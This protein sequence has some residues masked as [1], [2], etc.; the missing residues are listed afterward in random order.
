MASVKGTEKDGKRKVVKKRTRR[1]AAP[2]KETLSETPAVTAQIHPSKQDLQ[3]GPE[4]VGPR[5]T[6]E[7]EKDEK[8]EGKKKA[9][10]YF[11]AV[12]RRKTAVARVRLST[13]QGDF[14]VNS[15]PCSVYFPTL[16]LRG[17]AEDALAKMKLSGHFRVSA[18]ISGGGIHAQAEALRHGLSRCLVKFNADFRK[19]LKRVKFLTRDSRMRERKKFGLKKARRAPQWQKR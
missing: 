14:T 17:I 10:R 5:E 4:V 9:E 3:T 7:F 18:K 13:R 12:G 1:T 11:E 15:R 6:G 2:E 16:E 19:R 8:I